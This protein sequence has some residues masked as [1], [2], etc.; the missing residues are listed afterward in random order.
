MLGNCLIQ[1]EA[2]GQVTDGVAGGCLARYNGCALDNLVSRR[3]LG[4]LVSE[5]ATPKIS[6]ADRI[7]GATPAQGE[8]MF[9]RRFRRVLL[10]I[11]CAVGLATTTVSSAFG[12]VDWCSNDPPVQLVLPSGQPLVVNVWVMVRPAQ[13]AALRSATV[14]GVV[15]NVQGNVATANLYVFIPNPNNGGL[16]F[17]VGA[18]PKSMGSSR[19]FPTIQG[20]SGTVLVMPVTITLPPGHL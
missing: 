15:T 14:S 16:S 4:W 3:R 11:I 7:E 17:P 20:T 10:S 19:N 6:R 9:A 18:A 1:G 2:G 8:S 5:P 12:Q 13:R